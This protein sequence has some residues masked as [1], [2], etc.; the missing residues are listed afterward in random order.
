MQYAQFVSQPAQLLAAFDI[1]A[2]QDVTR[3]I[4]LGEEAAL[5]IGQG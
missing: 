5:G 2:E 4:D 1:A 3:R